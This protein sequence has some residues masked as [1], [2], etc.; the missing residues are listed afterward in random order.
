MFLSGLERGRRHLMRT[1]YIWT[2]TKYTAGLKVSLIV[3]RT[4]ECP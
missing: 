3:D 1:M 2:R 4:E